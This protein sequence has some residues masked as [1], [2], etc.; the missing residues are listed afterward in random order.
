M[1]NV[2]EKDWVTKSG[3]RAV[4]L[5][6]IHSGRESHR[7]GYVEV[8]A[9]HPLHEVDYNAPSP[10]LGEAWKKAKEGP[11]GARGMI[12]LVLSAYMDD[13][14]PTAESVFDV[15]GSITFSGSGSA[16]YPTESAG[17]W[18]GFDC[19]HAGDA[20][21]EPYPGWPKEGVVRTVEYAEQQCERLAEQI[22]TVGQVA[23]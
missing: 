20:Q 3:L 2:V 5:M 8:K 22:A 6:C 14:S 21:I 19:N 4:V 12:P 17:W 23:P 7:C 10:A 11:V 15:H 13:A 9:G 16:K 18:F 1:A